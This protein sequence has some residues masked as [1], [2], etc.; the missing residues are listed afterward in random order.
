MVAFQD[1]EIWKIDVKTTFLDGKLTKDVYMAQQEGFVQS[2]SLNKVCKLEK[3]IYRLKQATDRWNI[4]FNEKI[5]GVRF[6][7]K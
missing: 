2:K 3:F 5:Q 7:K 4:Y 1:Y 6:L